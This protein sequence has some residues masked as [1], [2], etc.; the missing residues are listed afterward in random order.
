MRRQHTRAA[1]RRRRQGSAASRAGAIA[2]LL[3]ASLLLAACGRKGPP[4]AP[5][6]RI[7]AAIE[8]IDMRRVGDDALVTLTVPAANLDKSVPVDV[9]R[10]EVYAFTALTPPPRARFLEGARLVGMFPVAPLP[11]PGTAAAATPAPPPPS[12]TGPA[13]APSALPGAAVTIRDVLGADD[14]VPHELPPPPGRR[15]ALVARA[16]ALVAA[17]AATELRRFYVAIPFSSRGVAGPPSAI[18]SLPLTQ[19]PERPLDPRATYG[20]ERVSVEWD[21]A[22]GLIGFLFDRALPPEPPPSDRFDPA[23]LRGA[24]LVPGNLPPGPTRYNVY[25]EVAPDPLA[26]PQRPAPTPEWAARLAVPVNQTPLAAP[27]YSEAAVFDGRQVCYTVSAVRGTAPDLVEGPRS[28]RVCVTPV[29]IFPPAAPRGLSAVTEEGVINLVWEPNA[30]TDLGGYVV[31]RGEA[32]DA[33]LAP[34]VSQPIAETRY[35]D[36]S[37]ESGRR[38]VYAVVAADARI[39]LPNLSAESARVEEVA[40]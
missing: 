34:L 28:D 21:P 22:G 32:G 17:P 35:A 12:A 16:A 1:T 36:R 18:V 33:T 40:R 29:D 15:E 37:V 3:A 9:R 8:K 23:A 11:V 5:F 30:E 6:V 38:Y 7:P 25:R 31:L 39:P 10:V 24:A 26:L 19:L 27:A 2:W 13:P 20:A 4:L 14:L